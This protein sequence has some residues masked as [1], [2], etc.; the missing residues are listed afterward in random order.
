VDRRRAL[1]PGREQVAE[2]DV[3]EGA[4]HHDLVV[5]APRAVRVEVLPLDAVLD[6][7]PASR[8]VGPDRS[9]GRDVVRRDAVA[10][11]DEA[12]RAGNVVDPPGL[13]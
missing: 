12:A 3:R 9:G 5:P 6:Q 7:V 1:A 4:S 10:G 2:A 8:A 13:A 11:P